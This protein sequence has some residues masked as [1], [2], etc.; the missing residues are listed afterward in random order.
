MSRPSSLRDGDGRYRR[1]QPTA[2]GP[3]RRAGGFYR[4]A[5]NGPKR[6]IGRPLKTTE[7]AVVAA[8]RMAYDIAD[9]QIDRS[10]RIATRLKAAGDATTGGDSDRLALQA[11]ERLAM[12]LASSGLA[13]LESAAAEPGSP[14]WRLL[15][16]EYRLLGRVFGLAEQTAAPPA[17]SPAPDPPA[18][19]P[20]FEGARA[21]SASL[22]LLARV[23]GKSP[24]AVNATLYSLAELGP[25]PLD[26]HFTRPGTAKTFTGR[27]DEDAKRGALVLDLPEL[28]KYAAGSW[29]AP[30]CDADGV[31]LGRIEL[32][33]L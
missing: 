12:K 17:A 30:V 13:W 2:Q 3:D 25:G 8:V 16:A 4:S 14:L 24:R 29:I 5:D 22:R 33:L 15:A 19:P 20:A 32:E 6:V 21:A 26:C 1:P 7:D 10:L 11:G 28:S 27:L 31:Q 9:E 18:A 23:K